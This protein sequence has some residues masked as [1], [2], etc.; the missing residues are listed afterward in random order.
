MSL[1]EFKA[2]DAWDFARHTGIEVKPRGD[3]LR[4]QMC[5]YCRGGTGGKKDKDTFA[6]NLI[7]GQ[8]KCMRASCSASG[9]MLT[10]SK[11][12][13]FSLGND[14]DSYYNRGK[15]KYRR[16]KK[17]EKPIEPK[18]E[19]LAYLEK[20]GISVGT[21]KRYQITTQS[22]KPNILVFPFLD[23]TGQM[24]FVKYR[25]T[26]FDPEKDKNKEWCETGCKPILFGMY[27]CKPEN[28]TLVLTEGQIDSLS[29]AEAGVENAVSVPTGKNGFTWFPHCW[30]WL[31]QFDTL[32]V[33]GDCER[34]EITLLEDM[35]R[36]FPGRVKAVRQQD[37]KGCKDANE[38]LQ[39]HGKAAV[40]QAVEQAEDIPVNQVKELADVR[41]VDLFSLPKIPTGIMQLDKVLGGGIYLGQTAIITGKRGD[42]K[43][44]LASQIVGNAL[45]QGRTVFAYSGELPDYFFKRWLD[46]QLAGRGN[47]ISSAAPDGNTNYSI[48]NTIAERISGWYRGRAF[49]FDSQVADDQEMGDLLKVVEKA[50]QQYGIELV[51]L[52]NLMTALDIGMEVD[53]YRAQSKFVDKLVKLSKRLNIAV[54]L[55]AHP[56]K[57]RFGGDDTDEVAGSSD[58]TNKVDIVMTYKRGKDMPDTERFLSV[59]KN[60]LT[61]RL[62]VGDKELHLYYDPVS[63]RISDRQE[64]FDRKY[65]WE[66]EYNGFHLLSESEQLEIPFE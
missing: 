53:L 10:L 24:Q 42:G 49:L 14:V 21:A 41:N 23:E 52:D 54:I 35:R 61:G 51:L 38:I 56:R 5:P 16:F 1:Y 36:R 59:S 6:I 12:F 13:G 26:D 30:D 9:N 18:P 17:P 11:D 32:I 62:A 65:A 39:K 37:Y 50:V 55:V 28:K 44:T 63:K 33:F 15:Q 66:Y 31:Q 64:D 27:Q 45:N 2:G 7:T 48:T 25:K 19:A 47:I 3:E 60:R 43:S 34:G 57:N 4:F 58:I 8:Y 22:D 29:A 46:M 40:Q 20:R